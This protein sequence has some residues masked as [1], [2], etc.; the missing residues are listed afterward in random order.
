[1]PAATVRPART[2]T[3]TPTAALLSV[4]VSDPNPWPGEHNV[5]VTGRGFDPTQQYQITFVQGLY[6]QVLFGPASPGSRG[7]FSSPVRIPNSA[8]PGPAVLVG[9][10]YLVN[11]GPTGRCAM[12]QVVVQ[13]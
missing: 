2:P 9:C 7:D 4:T 13:D 3:P 11:V 1:V 6:V 12:A 8:G 10:V 5:V